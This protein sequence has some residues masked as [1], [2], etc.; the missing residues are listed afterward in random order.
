MQLEYEKLL[1]KEAI[2][3]DLLPLDIVTRINNMNLD[4]KHLRKEYKHAPTI[5]KRE[6][7]VK[8][9]IDLG[10]CNTIRDWIKARGKKNAPFPFIAKKEHVNH[11]SH[12]GGAD[13]PYEAIKVIEAW[14]L[15]FKLGNCVKY[16]SRAG[17]K[18]AVIQELKKA[19]WYL[20]R[21]IDT[22]EKAE[23]KLTNLKKA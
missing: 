23:E 15:G 11:P 6:L 13:N 16:I 8:N 9:K 21:E 5:L 12:Y 17:K 20:Q 18:D 10:I 1:K 3:F 19:A 2:Q 4:I 7:R 14:D 22:L